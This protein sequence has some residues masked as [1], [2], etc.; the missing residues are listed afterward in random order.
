MTTKNQPDN[1]KQRRWKAAFAISIALSSSLAYSVFCPPQYQENMVEPQFEA[2]T[3]ILNDAI[4]AVDTALST[5]L[6]FNSERLVSAIAVLT[7]QKA[8]SGNQIADSARTASQQVATAMNVMAQTERVKKARFDY[9]GEFGQG[10]SPCKVY[11]QRQVIA[12]RDADMENERRERVL[13]EVIASPGRYYDPISGHQ[14]ILK[15]NRKFCTKE[16]VESGLCSEEGDMPAAS[17]NVATLFE[18]AME[19]SELYDAKVTFVN[20]MVGLP[21]GSVP[22]E[23]GKSTAATSYMLDKSFKD[24]VASPAIVALKEIQLDNSGVEGAETGSDIPLSLHFK[25]EVNRYSGNAKEYDEWSKV[26]VAQN[27]RGLMVELLKMNA[28]KLA[29]QEKMYRQYEQTEAMLAALVAEELQ[30]SG[31][32]NKTSEAGNDAAKQEV[33]KSIQ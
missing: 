20:N 4:S 33:N 17:M 15:A 5:Q 10:F 9:G 29:L 19:G 1:K 7:K 31:A 22:K 14:E 16:Q 28:L 23:A 3:E 32:I 27:D 30:S 11:A 12:N 21:D 2:A 6:D 8:V 25:N 18:P 13:S 26:L 24:A